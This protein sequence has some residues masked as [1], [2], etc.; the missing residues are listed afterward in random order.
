MSHD[1]ISG[2]WKKH[3]DFCLDRQRAEDADKTCHFLPFHDIFCDRD[4]QVASIN[5]S[6]KDQKA[7]KFRF[8]SGIPTTCSASM[9]IP[10]AC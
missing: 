6:R 10:S 9:A 7:I 4:I 2:D 8:C 1:S 5:F 3:L